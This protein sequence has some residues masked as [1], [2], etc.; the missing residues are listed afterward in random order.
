LPKRPV[1]RRAC[2]RRSLPGSWPWFET[3]ADRT[4]SRRP[5]RIAT[6]SRTSRTFRS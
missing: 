2:P 1:P 6:Q 4:D 3:R 5:H